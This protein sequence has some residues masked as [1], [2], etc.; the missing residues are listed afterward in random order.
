LIKCLNEFLY[1]IKND[2]N[3]TRQLYIT[4]KMPPTDSYLVF[5]FEERCDD[6][7]DKI[8]N[9][10]FVSYDVEQLS[11]VVYGRRQ[12]E[13]LEFEQFFF[14]SDRSKDMYKFFKFMLGDK[15]ELSYTLFN[16]NNMPF[17][18]EEVDYYFM[19]GNMAISHE[20]AA[21]DEVTLKRK[22]FREMMHLLK[23]VYNFC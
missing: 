18:L 4:S 10:L 3:V 16:Y 23:R 9:R 6:D 21:Y 22:N 7:Y 15:A 11:Y 17:D 12:S 19:E 8:T 13:T 20:L 1:I 5:C 2:L 14:R